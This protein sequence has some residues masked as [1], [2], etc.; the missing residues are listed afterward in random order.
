MTSQKE[1]LNQ[2][3]LRCNAVIEMLGKPTE[4]VSEVMHKLIENLETK[5][6]NIELISKT[7][8]E[9]IAAEN[10]L[11]STFSEVEILVKD[12]RTLL[13]F[14]LSYMPSNIEVVEPKEVS[15]ELNP[16]NEFISLF[17]GKVHQ[18]DAMMKRMDLENVM[19]TNKVESMLRAQEEAKNKE[20]SKDKQEDSKDNEAVKEEIKEEKLEN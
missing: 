15:F 20:E 11:Y 5:E 8:H 16:L 3:W 18:Y 14:T 2:G 10:N 9:P 12:L 7:I 6:Q 4:Y 1:K 17:A 13:E 19:L